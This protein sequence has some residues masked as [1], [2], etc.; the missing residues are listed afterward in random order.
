MRDRETE[1]INGIA[2]TLDAIAQGVGIKFKK[3]KDA[4]MAQ[5]VALRD[6]VEDHDDAEEEKERG[7]EDE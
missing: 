7:F 2:D 6:L 1:R 4:I 3:L 5:V